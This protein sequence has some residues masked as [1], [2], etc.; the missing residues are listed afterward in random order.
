MH[1]NNGPRLIPQVGASLPVQDKY[2]GFLD[3]TGQFPDDFAYFAEVAYKHFAPYA[4]YWVT[5]NEPLSICQLGYGIGIFAPGELLP[6]STV[7][8]TPNHPTEQSHPYP[9][10]SQPMHIV[11]HTYAHVMSFLLEC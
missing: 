1:V 11:K 8:W 10:S 5:F 4:Q 3:K 6:V 7:D 2:G 9:H